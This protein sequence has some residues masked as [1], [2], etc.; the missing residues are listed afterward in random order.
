MSSAVGA[1]GFR[2]YIPD[3]AIKH[4]LKFGQSSDKHSDESNI[5]PISSGSLE[6]YYSQKSIPRY[7]ART[8]EAVTLSRGI[9]DSRF[10]NGVSFEVNHLLSEPF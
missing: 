2:I 5:R 10:P 8:K 4:G 1:D 7:V 3:R 6:K 9:V